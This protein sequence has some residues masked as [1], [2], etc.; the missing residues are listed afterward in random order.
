MNQ[1]KR[2]KVLGTLAAFRTILERYPKL[3][4]FDYNGGGSATITSISSL[5]EILRLIGV[6][7]EFLYKWLANLLLD[8]EDS[9]VKKGVLIAIEESVKAILL[10]YLNSLYTCP[11]DP[12]LPDYFLNSPYR[13][14]GDVSDDTIECPQPHGKGIPI[15]VSKIDAFGLL[16]NCPVSLNGSVF[17]FDTDFNASNVYKSTDMNAY[18]WYVI[19]KGNRDERSIWD[20]RVLYRWQFKGEEGK[21]KQTNFVD[22][23]CACAPSK[24]VRGVGVKN[25][26]VYAE[27]IENGIGEDYTNLSINDLKEVN[28]L[29]VF[30]MADRYYRQGLRLN[31]SS[32]MSGRMNKTIR[33]FN[34]D[35][36]YSLKLFDSKTLFAGVINAMLGISSTFSGKFSLQM[37]I[38]IRKIEKLV[39]RVVTMEGVYDEYEN[40]PDAYFI[41]SDRQYSE[42]ENDATL[43]YNQ[44]YETGNDTNDLEDIDVNAIS[45]S[46]RMI[47]GGT[48]E[49]KEKNI[50][51]AITSI[52]SKMSNVPT[53]DASAQFVFE[54]NIV[55]KFLKEIIVQIAMQLLSPKVMLLFAINANFLEETQENITSSQQWE[56][57]FKNF[58]NIMRSCI[59]SI[60]NVII[61]A[62]VDL[63]IGQI[64]PLIRLVAK[65]LMLESIYYYKELIRQLILACSLN[66]NRLQPEN[67]LIDNVNYA[68]IIP[69]QNNPVTA[70][71]STS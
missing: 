4:T 1:E 55:Y 16:Q 58:W 54:N 59:N 8:E 18:L 17:Y 34:T 63:I 24:V 61:Q 45:D 37:N 35:Y 66:L 26:I 23:K 60:A 13:D 32:I 3:L 57:F 2:N 20:N 42:I 67:L 33:Q 38:A 43:R 5:M 36:I 25:E 29:H 69:E 68:D 11:V 71:T 56:E 44:K 10:G 12:I 6:S 40:E 53:I 30:G 7:N 51:D 9:G 27:F 39:E 52:S 22:T 46:I 15:P 21:E 47:E 19:N 31:G 64:R 50:I 62:I 48:P 65:K 70:V 49:E 28:S 41:F 14:T